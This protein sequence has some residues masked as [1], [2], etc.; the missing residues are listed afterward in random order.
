[1]QELNDQVKML[2][3]EY[4]NAAANWRAERVA[5]EKQV[6]FRGG[7]INIPAITQ[8]CCMSSHWNAGSLLTLLVHRAAHFVFCG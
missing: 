4:A 2:Y 7:P 1:M 3:R 6:C 8:R 5:T